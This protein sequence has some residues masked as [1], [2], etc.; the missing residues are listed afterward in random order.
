MSERRLRH[1]DDIAE[2][3]QDAFFYTDGSDYNTWYVEVVTE[4]L[5]LSSQDKLVD[6]GGGTGNFTAALAEHSG[7]RQ[8]PLNVE[9]FEEMVKKSPPSLD[10]LQLDAHAFATD[11]KANHSYDRLLMKE[12]VHHIE[13]DKLGETFTGIC[14]QLKPGGRVLIVT[15]PSK[16]IEYPF[17]KAAYEV[18]QQDQAECSVYVDVLLKAGFASVETRI[19]PYPCVIEKAQWFRMIK[20]RFWS[21][22]S[23]FTEEELD[24]GIKELEEKYELQTH[25]EFTD[26]LVFITAEHY[27]DKRCTIS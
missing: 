7:L 10:T 11:A 3:Y 23:N 8:K 20:Q 1:Y 18:W 9:P 16:D 6:I 15:R 5:A 21:T 14:S 22:F 19:K 2:G 27:L 4:A 26:K 13:A 17:F 25:L 24:A 12:V